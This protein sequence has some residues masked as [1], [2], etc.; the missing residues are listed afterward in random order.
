MAGMNRRTL[1]QSIP[2]LAA[3]SDHKRGG[4]ANFHRG[5]TTRGSIPTYDGK[6]D[7]LLARFREHHQ[8]V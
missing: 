1:L 5:F 4:S 6:L 8:A 3:Q 7:D 2:A